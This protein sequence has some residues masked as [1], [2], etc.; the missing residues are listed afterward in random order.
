MFCPF[1]LLTK[2]LNHPILISFKSKIEA[3]IKDE[4]ERK[5]LVPHI[6]SLLR[7]CSNKC[8]A[9]RVIH[10]HESYASCIG[11]V[12]HIYKRIFSCIMALF[13]SGLGTTANNYLI[14]DLFINLLIAKTDSR[15]LADPACPN[16]IDEINR[17]AKNLCRLDLL[18]KQQQL[19]SR[20][21]NVIIEY[22]RSRTQVRSSFIC[23]F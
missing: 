16:L 4:E 21:Y 20:D 2:K 10:L 1:F 14:K 3:I 23:G 6:Y 13:E 5:L 7:A 11:G 9:T 18:H 17:V 8:I 12:V 15:V 22:A 19:L